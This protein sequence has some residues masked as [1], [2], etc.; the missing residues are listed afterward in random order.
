MFLDKSDTQLLAKLERRNGK[1]VLRANMPPP[2][3]PPH[4]N[5][6]ITDMINS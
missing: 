6:Y 4:L 5:D 2:P 3:P 1:F